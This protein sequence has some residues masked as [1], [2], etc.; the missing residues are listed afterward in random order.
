VVSAVVVADSAA[1]VLQE[2]GDMQTL[3]KEFLT[4][5]EQQAV[6]AVVK[7]AER[8]TSGEIV[9]MIV[10]ASHHYPMATIRGAALIALPLALLCASLFGSSFWLGRDNMY[11]FVLFFLLFYFPLRLIINR[12]IK[13]KRMFLNRFEVEEEVQE[14][15]ITSFYGEGLYRTRE[16]NGILIFVSVLEQ[17]V[18]VLGDRG[19]NDKIHPTEWET[20]VN[21]LIQGIKAGNQGEALCGAVLEVG[22]ILKKH[23]PYRRDDTDEL[24][25]LIIR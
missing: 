10:S 3:A 6:T 20:I 11:L 7:Q 16:A 9:P 15:A 4:D 21:K 5:S 12:S 25:N 19:I 14:A 23:F 1:A 2:D 13:L 22:D 24:H 8:E 18:W 17:K